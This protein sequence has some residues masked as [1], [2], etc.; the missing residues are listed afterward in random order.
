M[1]GIPRL[2]STLLF[3][4][5][6]FNKINC[7][8]VKINEIS[9]LD[10]RLLVTGALLA[11]GDLKFV[12]D[13]IKKARDR[14]I[15]TRGIIGIVLDH[16]VSVHDGKK[17]K[18]F[19]G[20]LKEQ[21]LYENGITRE[22]LISTG[23]IGLRK[24]DDFIITE[25]RNHK[26]FIKILSQTAADLS[27]IEPLKKI[28]SYNYHAVTGIVD[29]NYL[30]DQMGSSFFLMMLGNRCSP[31][32]LRQ[33]L[34][35]YR[36]FGFKDFDALSTELLST[37]SEE[38]KDSV[39]EIVQF[40]REIKFPCHIHPDNFLISKSK[41]IDKNLHRQL[42]FANEKQLNQL[43]LKL[44]R[45]TTEF[46]WENVDATFDSFFNLESTSTPE[47]YMI[48]FGKVEALYLNLIHNSH[49]KSLKHQTP[50]L[51]RLFKK[52]YDINPDQT[53]RKLNQWSFYLTKSKN[54]HNLALILD[55]I[56]SKKSHGPKFK[57]SMALSHTLLGASS[58]TLL[59]K[60]F[61][62]VSRTKFS[63]IFYI[64]FL[65][66]QLD[67]ARMSEFELMIQK[68]L[69]TDGSLKNTISRFLFAIFNNWRIQTESDDLAN[70]LVKIMQKNHLLSMDQVLWLQFSGIKA[71]M[72]TGETEPNTHLDCEEV[73]EYVMVFH[74]K[75]LKSMEFIKIYG[76]VDH[77]IK[78][79]QFYDLDILHD[80]FGGIAARL[81]VSGLSMRLVDLVSILSVHENI[82]D[83]DRANF[84]SY[85]I[86]RAI[87]GAL[88]GNQWSTLN[89]MITIHTNY[90]EP[91]KDFLIDQISSK[92]D[93]SYQ[94]YSELIKIC[95]KH[96]IKINHKASMMV[97]LHF[98]DSSNDFKSLIPQDHRY[99]SL[100]CVQIIL[101][102]S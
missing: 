9:H 36:I 54:W 4:S 74:P 16:F 75:I 77:L 99:N 44:D 92:I 79:V 71:A 88:D 94:N 84:L 100:E 43:I 56:A 57:P 42:K 80:F 41:K 35:F 13:L 63:K 60:L 49:G 95:K 73:L 15:K 39:K 101:E 53:F 102:S 70:F 65:L 20:K 22:S 5:F 1:K 24:I 93:C 28:E 98:F 31:S 27:C 83:G 66:M 10:V 81:A 62:L 67:Y 76:I 26:S 48:C 21:K 18:E 68:I 3:W 69:S 14:N 78:T 47:V 86:Q 40:L 6:T 52:M 37:L 85:V 82:C 91:R 30:I 2:L 8:L 89:T 38:N 51:L 17:F 23:L 46:S 64:K 45:L 50:Y 87:K 32:T 96:S 25:T 12:V 7:N 58:N 90:Y 11:K 59:E 55:F 19:I 29:F 34:D 61:D 33:I 72:P 97:N